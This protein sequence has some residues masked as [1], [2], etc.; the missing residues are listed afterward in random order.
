M[1]DAK[2]M[3]LL[4]LADFCELAELT[5]GGQDK[6][7]VAAFDMM[8]NSCVTVLREDGKLE[9]LRSAGL[10]IIAACDRPPERHLRLVKGGA[11]V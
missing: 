10:R 11:N 3:P 1:A 5:L 2:Q 7:S 6:A 9:N 8:L 4:V